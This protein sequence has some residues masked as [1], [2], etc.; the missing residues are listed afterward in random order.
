MSSKVKMGVLGL[1]LLDYDT[2][3]PGLKES[4]EKFARKALKIFEDDFEFIF[5]NVCNTREDI[6]KSIKEFEYYQCSAIIV[7]ML[8]YCPSV[9]ILP[10]LISTKLPII[11]Y[12]TQE[13]FEFTEQSLF[14]DLI[15]NHGVH[16]VQD[17]CSVLLRS[18]VKYNLVV[19]HWQDVNTTSELRQAMRV[20]AT[21]K[22]LKNSRIGL[23]GYAMQDMGDF[24]LDETALL[25]KV[26][27]HVIHIPIDE[28]ANYTETVTLDEIAVV[29]DEQ[30][31][32]Y[33]FDKSISE[34]VYNENAKMEVAVRKIV[35]DYKLDA[36]AQYFSPV[37]KNPRIKTPPFFVACK[38]MKEGIGYA[39]EGDVSGA[40]GGII[41]SGLGGNASLCEMFS[42]DFGGETLVMSHMAE[43]NIGMA[44]KDC[45]V[46]VLAKDFSWASKDAV[47]PLVPAITLEPGVATILSIA[48]KTKGEF[49]FV[50][51]EG[52]IVDFKHLGNID[53]PVFK[54]KPQKSIRQ[55][56]KEYSIAGGTHHQAI[57]Y[58][59]LGDSI[60]L[61]GDM[62]NIEV[63]RI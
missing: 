9:I 47:S 55:F 53:C 28:L 44:R 15:N 57:A 24:Y 25:T 49:R 56:L 12:D 34:Q 60:Q 40:S 26:G 38:L 3:F 21:M 13:S 18:E 17:L 16:G 19:G 4:R 51:I 23:F 58:G 63:V 43:V 36:W 59:K 6:E 31:V 62:L 50:V 61:L 5:N 33:D 52:E 30:A 27:P 22:K 41:L 29:I 37:I 35:K 14:K 32:L 20:A 2:G 1:T 42:I 46:K 10:G 54:F 45:S 39:A 48:C 7:L 8:T 11:I